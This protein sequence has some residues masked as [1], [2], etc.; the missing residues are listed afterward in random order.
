MSKQATNAWC[1]IE[2][3]IF[4]VAIIGGIISTKLA[5]LAWLSFL[6]LLLAHMLLDKNYMEEWCKWLWK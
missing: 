2:T 3:L 4:V 5:C 6:V 1:K